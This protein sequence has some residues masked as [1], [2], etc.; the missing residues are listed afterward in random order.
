MPLFFGAFI[1]MK[2][3]EIVYTK[4]HVTNHKQAPNTIKAGDTHFQPVKC[5]FLNPTAVNS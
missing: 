3:Q 1:L 2:H 4:S 5:P